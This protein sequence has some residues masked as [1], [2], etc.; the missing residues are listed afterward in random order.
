MID[1]GIRCGVNVWNMPSEA[2]KYWSYSRECARQ[3]AQAKTSERRGRLLELSSVWTAA[4]IREESDAERT[5]STLV[6]KRG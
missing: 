1:D 2:K 3:A 5:L 4:A 6:R